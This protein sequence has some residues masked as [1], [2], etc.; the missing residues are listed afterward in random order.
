MFCKPCNTEPTNRQRNALIAPDEASDDLRNQSGGCLPKLAKAAEDI[1]RHALEFL[2]RPQQHQ[3]TA[4]LA[5]PSNEAS[6]SDNPTASADNNPNNILTQTPTDVLRR[7]VFYLSDQSSESN[8]SER[9]S[10]ALADPELAKLRFAEVEKLH[11]TPNN[12]HEIILQNKPTGS[13]LQENRTPKLS[14]I[15]ISENVEPRQVRRLLNA[16]CERN[17]I[18]EISFSNCEDLFTVSSRLPPQLKKLSFNGCTS[19]IALPRK[20]PAGLDEIEIT[21]CNRIVTLSPEWPPQLKT[22]TVSDCHSLESITSPLPSQLKELN[23][24]QCHNLSL[25]LNQL[26]N[27]IA[28]L[29]LSYCYKLGAIHN[30]HG[31]LTG[32]EALQWHIISNL[33]ELNLTGSVYAS[34]LASLPNQLNLLNVSRIAQVRL[35]GPI[36][37][38]I[39]IVAVECDG[40]ETGDEELRED[41]ITWYDNEPPMF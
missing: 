36:P 32:T 12:I 20:F 16:I 35:S 40:I 29:D 30:A 21:N 33:Q 34:N 27:S 9:S 11:I 8:L 7:S 19:L 24:R 22:L 1:G 2:R 17:S 13:L 28:K 6:R 41:Q 5:Q 10:F 38:A 14:K 15:E 23:A 18:S 3:N 25:D 39:K 37:E 31:R 26:P 4:S